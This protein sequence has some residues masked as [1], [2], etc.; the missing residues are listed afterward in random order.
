MSHKVTTPGKSGEPLD[1]QSLAQH[2]AFGPLAFQAAL[3]LRDHGVLELGRRRGDE[4]FVADDACAASKLSRYAVQV[5]LDAGTSSGLFTL[6]DDRYRL[7]TVGLYVLKDRMTRAN[8]DFVQDVCYLGAYRLGDALREGRPA[9]LEVFGGWPTIYEGLKDL[10]EGVRRSW[11]AFDHFYSDGVFPQLVP[12]VL[13]RRPRRILDC[14]GNTGKW[15]VQL[16]GADPELRV[17]ILD[18]PGQLA[19]ARDNVA[20]RGLADRLD[21]RPFDFLVQDAPLPGGHDVVWMSQFL[22]CFSEDEIV[23]ILSRARAAMDDDARLFILETY[24]DRQS[25]PTAAYVLAMTS[26]YFAAMANGN[27]RMYHSRDLAAC[28]A[29]AGLELERDIDG[30]GMSHTLMICRRARR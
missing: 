1:A 8:M 20:A 14:G 23:S 16:L 9:G 7:T 6:A 26:L 21:T 17:T 15:A 10:P 19:N 29:A 2:L 18:H 25:H 11:F 3:L 28:I 5:L 22:D 12:M 13:E 30:I 4:G 27:S 24:W